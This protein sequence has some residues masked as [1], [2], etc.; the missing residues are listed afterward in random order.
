MIYTPVYIY[1]VQT[2]ELDNFSFMEINR[3]SIEINPAVIGILNS[4]DALENQAIIDELNGYILNGK[5]D[6]GN[7]YQFKNYC[8]K[9]FDHLDFSKIDKYPELCSAAST[10]RYKIPEEKAG[11]LANNGGFFIRTKSKKSQGVL[12]E[13]ERLKQMDAYN[14]ALTQYILGKY[15][16]TKTKSETRSI[17]VPAILS[18]AQEKILKNVDLYQEQ[19]IVGPPGTGKSYTIA[20]IAVN[21]ASKGNSVLVVSGNPQAV[22]VV[23]KK[24][25]Q[26]FGIKHLT[27]QISSSRKFKSSLYKNLR[28]WLNGSGLSQGRREIHLK[29]LNNGK[30]LLGEI[31]DIE[32]KLLKLETKEIEYGNYIL[33][34]DPGLL[35]KLK[36]FFVKR[37]I[38]KIDNHQIL[39]H[40]YLIALRKR[41]EIQRKVI[42]SG[43]KRQ[44][45]QALFDD[46]ELFLNFRQGMKAKVSGEKKNFFDAIDFQKLTKVFPVWLSPINEVHNA[47]PFQKEM[48]DVVI[49][50]EASQTDMASVLPILYR[51]KKVIVC[52]DP[53]QLRHISF[54]SKAKQVQFSQELEMPALTMDFDYRNTSFLDKFSSHLKSQNQVTFLDEHYRS[55]PDI[56]KF[57]NEHFYDNS[58][59][60]M[61][62]TPQNKLSNSQDIVCVNGIRSDKGTNEKEAHYILSKCTELILQQSDMHEDVVSTIGILSPFRDQID[63]IAK[64]IRENFRNIDV[65]KHRITLGTAHSFQGD[66]RDIMFISTAV[67]YDSHHGSFMHL[68]KDDIFN[69]S[70]TRAR[71]KQIIV[72]SVTKPE[73]L[74]EGNIKSLLLG[75]SNVKSTNKEDT[76]DL[77]TPLVDEIEIWL[78]N[79]KLDSIQRKSDIASIEVDLLVK[80]GDKHFG[81]DLVG[82][83]N[84][85][86]LQIGLDKLRILKRLNLTIFPI[87]VSDFKL[88][89]DNLTHVLRQFIQNL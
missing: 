75:E 65:K 10:K 66:E 3:D 11:V 67:N 77:L 33:N 45:K 60:I 4:N 68:N 14:P 59:R 73:L 47:L 78:Q 22:S 50:D 30:W 76:S 88:N 20:A 28:Q 40:Q 89:Q 26:D 31:N 55:L 7:L 74:K 27:T 15:Q 6:I 41:I 16:A 29:H 12:N 46:R 56:I 80:V 19:M 53:Q 17:F 32:K 57:S 81:I 24:I 82:V 49:F 85:A 87:S 79:F 72:H 42:N 51:A 25:S 70:L 52:G 35:D 1:D 84:E 62:D 44:L 71:K 48:F 61:T 13:I 2:T 8:E 69:V 37:S 38:Q 43:F 36:V 63:F 58:L 21:E 54:L 39:Y 83:A 5:F 9:H 23:D 34:A 18:G 86:G 64:L